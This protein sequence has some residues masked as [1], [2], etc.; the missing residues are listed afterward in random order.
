MI[1]PCQR[2]SLRGFSR[3]NL[4]LTPKF[5]V[6]G[7]RHSSLVTFLSTDARLFTTNDIFAPMNGPSALPLFSGQRSAHSP[8]STLFSRRWPIKGPLAHL[9]DR[10]ASTH[11][12]VASVQRADGSTQRHCALTQNEVVPMRSAVVLTQY[13]SALTQNEIVLTQNGTVLTRPLPGLTQRHVAEA[14][15]P[16]QCTH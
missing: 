2:A 5:F 13:H 1:G 9:Q 4:I 7:L 16:A 10:D 11:P 15:W 14:T 3:S 8:L 12:L 6:R